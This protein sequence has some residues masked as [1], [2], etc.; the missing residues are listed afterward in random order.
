MSSPNE[1]PNK[2][3]ARDDVLAFLNDLD[4]F[5]PSTETKPT[6][7]SPPKRNILPQ[8]PASSLQNSVQKHDNVNSN[9]DSSTQSTATKPTLNQPP[10]LP[11]SIVAPPQPQKQAEPSTVATPIIQQQ[12]QSSESSSWFSNILSISENITKDLNNQLT[13]L[14][15]NPLVQSSLSTAKSALTE[16]TTILTENTQEIRSDFQKLIPGLGPSIIK[17]PMTIWMCIESDVISSDLIHDRIQSYV[18]NWHDCFERV[19]VNSVRDPD[20]V[21]SQ[22]LVS[23][24]SNADLVYSRL[25]KLV[26]DVE[27]VNYFFVIVPFETACFLSGV[28]VNVVQ[29][30]AVFYNG[31]GYFAYNIS[32]SCTD[33]DAERVVEDCM[34]DVLDDVISKLRKEKR[35]KQ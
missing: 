20:L 13:N 21:E 1:N 31:D 28:K 29:W 22:N 33:S 19:I 15:A 3:T 14:S 35:E 24:M 32:K 4:S 34:Y 17:S 12:K 8:R 9:L 27:A 7:Q 16:A 10:I 11:P 23:A 18:C 25:M 26:V 2:K 6:P 30:A 5:S